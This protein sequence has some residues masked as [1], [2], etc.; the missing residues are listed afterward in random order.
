M[1]SIVCNR[2]VQSG[3]VMLLVA[4]FFLITGRNYEFGTF[5]MMGP[6]FVPLSLSILMAVL[7][8]VLIVWGV[9]TATVDD[10]NPFARFAL[11]PTILVLGA[12]ALFALTLPVLGY[13]VACTLLV[14]IGGMA[15]PDR[16][17]VEV[18]ISAILISGITGL[19]FIEILALPMPLLPEGF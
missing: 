5:E 15:A 1:R 2:E 14:L 17:P 18:A 4:A 9:R 12:I 3:A 10:I 6:G 11:K 16:R 19:I 7:G 13:L 8:F